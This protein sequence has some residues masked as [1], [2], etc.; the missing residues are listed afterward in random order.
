MISAGP[1]DWQHVPL[2]KPQWVPLPMTHIGPISDLK[3]ATIDS[4]GH[5]DG[6]PW[7]PFF[8]GTQEPPVGPTHQAKRAP[9]LTTRVLC[10]TTK[11]SYQATKGPLHYQLNRVVDMLNA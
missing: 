6:P 5:H 4:K 3:A 9:N 11:A 7:P 1:L 2:V 8:L 10:Q